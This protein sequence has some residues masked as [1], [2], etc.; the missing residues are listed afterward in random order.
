MVSD[1]F[2]V[3]LL[4]LWDATGASGAVPQLKGAKAFSFEEL[5][6]YTNNFAESNNIGTGGYGT[7][8]VHM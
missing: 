6:R 2:C 7:V 5:N 8:S 4:A 3:K 1:H